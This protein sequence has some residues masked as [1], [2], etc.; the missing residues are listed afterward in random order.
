MTSFLSLHQLKEVSQT[1]QTALI[2]YRAVDVLAK[3]RQEAIEA[4]SVVESY[5]EKNGDI[6]TL[7]INLRSW[8]ASLDDRVFLSEAVLLDSPEQI[9]VFYR[10][11]WKQ[12]DWPEEV[13][14]ESF[15]NSLRSVV[16]AIQASVAMLKGKTITEQPVIEMLGQQVEI[17]SDTHQTLRNHL[18]P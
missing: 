6:I 15:T 14:L 13:V 7:L 16:V 12:N 10:T 2:I 9:M 5:Y 4:M 8:Y 11:R 1:G 17:F 3:V 18:K